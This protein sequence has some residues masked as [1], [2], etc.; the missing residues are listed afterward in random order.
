MQGHDPEDLIPLTAKEAEA[1][2][3]TIGQVT[4]FPDRPTTGDR[5]PLYVLFDMGFARADIM[6][7]ALAMQKWCFR[8]LAAIVKPVSVLQAAIL[9]VCVE[10]TTWITPYRTMEPTRG[11]PD[12]I[13]EALRTLRG[14]AV[15]LE[16]LGIE[17]THIP[18]D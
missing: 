5:D 15:K 9:R 3:W 8:D 12:M 7:T 17:I 1:I 13:E 16:S 18:N 6:P 11:N 10:N 4:N 14:L 2:M